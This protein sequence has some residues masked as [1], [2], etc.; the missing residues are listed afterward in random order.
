MRATVNASAHK[1][2]AGALTPTSGST[3]P[4]LPAAGGGAAT[5]SVEALAFHRLGPDESTSTG[6]LPGV[7]SAA[8]VAAQSDSNGALFPLHL[9]ATGPPRPLPALL[10]AA[11]ADLGPT[12]AVARCRDRF[13]E[14]VAEAIRTEGAAPTSE[15][16]A[17]A[18]ASFLSNFEI[19]DQA[20]VEVGADANIVAGRLPADGLLLA[21]RTGTAL[22][23]YFAALARGRADAVAAL[24]ARAR[25]TLTRLNELLAVDARKAP[26]HASAEVVAASLGAGARL[27]DT[28]AFAALH[29][30]RPGSKRLT[31]AES[32]RV[33]GARIAIRAFLARGVAA[34]APIVLSTGPLPH[35]AV[36][37][38]A[39]AT[40]TPDAFDVIVDAFEE[41]AA[42]RVEILRWLRTAD[43]AIAH[44]WDDALHGPALASLT[45]EAC[46]PNE[47]LMLPPVVVVHVARP[48]ESQR[49]DELL[50][51]F[52]RVVRTGQ[53]IHAIIVE[54]TDGLGSDL[55]RGRVA[56]HHRAGVLT[57][58]MQR[59]AFVVQSTLANPG[60]LDSA[61][62]RLAATVR[63]GIAQIVAPAPNPSGADAAL[64]SAMSEGRGAACF[65][66]DPGLGPTWADR[67]ELSG[68]PQPD[69]AWPRYALRCRSEGGARQ[70]DVSATFVDAAALAPEL[71]R[72]FLV[73]P[74]E[75]WAD[76]QLPVAEFLHAGVPC[77]RVPFVWVIDPDG[78]L[79]RAVV[80]RELVWAARDRAHQ[81]RFVQELAGF[82][83]EH[84]VR[85]VAQIRSETAPRH[86]A[87]LAA[88]EAEHADAVEGA[89][90]QAVVEAMEGLV[91]LLLGLDA[92]VARAAGFALRAPRSADPPPQT[93]PSSVEA[94]AVPLAPEP[95][96]AEPDDP[97]IEKTYC[98]SCHECTN[99]NPLMFVYDENKQAEIVD[100]RLGTY[101]E[102]AHAAEKCP[103]RCIHPGKP[104]LDDVTVTAELL[105][106]LTELGL[107]TRPDPV[108]YVIDPHLCDGCTLCYE[109]CEDSAV[110]RDRGTIALVI[111][112]ERCT[113]C[114]GC[115]E[116][117]HFDA[118][119]KVPKPESADTPEAPGSVVGIV[120]RDVGG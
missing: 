24:D 55:A 49:S 67:F 120:A 33:E 115:F 38:S 116:V 83:N 93:E 114:G 5:T 45:W 74:V 48:G 73:I 46:E 8:L 119:A 20:E 29:P 97:F 50:A 110:I 89:R 15:T 44:D 52:S 22:R 81:W 72:H 6:L 17:A 58:V 82:G 70:L 68:N 85:A 75:E 79:G 88:L 28:N 31:A 25:R 103:S 13:L 56:A 78:S 42:E 109:R 1:P 66:Y 59:E 118:I 19:S 14:L 80:S 21:P 98:I 16:L 112:E 9:P 30:S 37:A 76:D 26:E 54:E 43:L 23:L 11:C 106:R 99:L 111:D 61:L 7:V 27:I 32:R 87:A 117:C 104:R 94:D 92:P 10:D 60:H 41:A 39:H 69:L 96:S 18:W 12:S 71:R 64:L 105:A 86:E 2:L 4:R 107:G 91:S 51:R 108:V 101:A 63:P 84:A 62:C 77:D 53:P 90:E 35:G 34:H 102:L 113:G 57:A 3:L 40:V 36:P 95:T 47:L 100:P 65:V